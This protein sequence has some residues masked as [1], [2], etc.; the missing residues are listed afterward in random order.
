MVLTW[1]E[2]NQIK[3]IFTPSRDKVLLNELKKI[4]CI[5]NIT[6]A[7]IQ[8]SRPQTLMIKIFAS[9]NWQNAKH[10]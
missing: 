7:Y 2:F 6:E 3:N 10:A 9:N 1:H 4:S 5:Q 8:P